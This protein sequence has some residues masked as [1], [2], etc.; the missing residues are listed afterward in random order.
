MDVVRV[1]P[2]AARDGLEKGEALLVSGYEDEAKFRAMRLEGAI[3][4]GELEARAPSL[5]R[6]QEIVFYCG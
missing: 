1:T 6:G 4:Y 3:S 2:Q 5:D